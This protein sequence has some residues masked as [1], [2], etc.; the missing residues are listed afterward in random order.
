M[1]KL[2]MWNMVT[3]DGY[4][5]GPDQDM[6]WFVFEVVDRYILETRLSADTLLYGRVTYQMM[7]GY[8]PSAEGPG[9]D[10]INTVPKIVCS[11]TLDKAEW[12]NT[13]L[14]KENVPD[15]ISKLKQQRGKDIVLFGSANL[16]ATLTA[17]GL[18]DEYRLAVNPVVLGRG[19]PLFK[20]SPDRLDLKLLG[21]RPLESGVVIL[22]YAPASNQS[23]SERSS[24]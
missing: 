4:F 12:S 18:I 10:F 16:A 24:S 15:E 17:H 23:P 1:R 22:H 8:W 19:T 6:S 3:V 13:T 21:T 5:E 2:I 20:D 9:A 11:R 14:V 7:A